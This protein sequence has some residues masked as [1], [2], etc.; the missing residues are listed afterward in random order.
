MT[1]TGRIVMALVGSILGFL[2]LLVAAGAWWWKTHSSELFAAGGTARVEGSAYAAETDLNG[3]VDHALLRS[4][5]C[6]DLEC[7]IAN[8]IF[9][10]ACLDAAMPMAEFCRDVPPLDDFMQSAMWRAEMCAEGQRHST[11]C[12]SLMGQIQEYCEDQ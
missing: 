5:A 8:N 1:R 7:Q 4:D 11:L 6:D 12:Q 10:Q 3:C 2:L 9:L